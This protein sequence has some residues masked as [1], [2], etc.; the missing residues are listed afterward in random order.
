M[1]QEEIKKL[2]LTITS[3]ENGIYSL[4]SNLGD[5]IQFERNML[6][7]MVVCGEV[8]K[9]MKRINL[10]TSMKEQCMKIP[11]MKVVLPET[12]T[13]VQRPNIEVK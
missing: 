5:L 13:K 7:G 9:Y 10:G 3:V 12:N 2:A 8:S 11:S 1:L 6:N 4:N